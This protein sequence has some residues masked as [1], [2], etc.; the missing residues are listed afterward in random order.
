MSKKVILITGASSGIGKE[1]AKKLLSEG[2]IVYAA[3]RRVEQM[4]D[5]TESGAITV[6]M[7]ISIEE[8]IRACID[9]IIKEQ[10]RID[11][12][13]NN[14]GFGLY[15]SVEE[16]SMD[17]ARYQFEV[18]IFGLARMTQLVVPYM[19]AQRKGIIINT[20]SVGGKIY[21]PLGAWYHATKHALEGWS[22]CLRLELKPFGIDVIVIEPGIIETSFGDVM[23]EPM[24]KTSGNGPYKDLAEAVAKTTKSSYQAGGGSSPGVVAN[25]VSK[26]IAAKNPKIRYAVGKMAKPLII[27]RKWISDRNFDRLIMSQMK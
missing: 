7:D 20:S 15:G 1:T 19:R 22:D 17:D 10:G 23:S 25:I 4:R 9:K 6:K 3:S 21:T 11:V 2:H 26:A 18:N 5:L 27:L 16:V 13:F 24:L 8:E 14:A 12:L